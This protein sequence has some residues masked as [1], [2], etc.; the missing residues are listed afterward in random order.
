MEIKDLT[1]DQIENKIET[2][3]DRIET[4]EEYISDEDDSYTRSNMQTH[5]HSYNLTLKAL[6]EEK[7][8]RLKYGKTDDIKVL[9]ENIKQQVLDKLNPRI[10]Y[11]AGLFREIKLNKSLESLVGEI[12]INS[13]HYNTFGLM[14]K[15]FLSQIPQDILDK[16]KIYIEENDIEEKDEYYNSMGTL[17][18]LV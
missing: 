11:Q 16:R 15:I 13:R 17:N 9:F 14:N 6:K 2:F 12:A 10:P 3:K 1:V 8:L 7:R 4:L 5:L 18:A